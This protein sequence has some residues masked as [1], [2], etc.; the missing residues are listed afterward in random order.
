M[1]CYCIKGEEEGSPRQRNIKKIINVIVTNNSKKCVGGANGSYLVTGGDSD[2]LATAI[3]Q[4][5]S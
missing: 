3:L 4:Q 1:S 5:E 2:E